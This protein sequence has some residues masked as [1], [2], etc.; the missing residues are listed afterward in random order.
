MTASG[1]VIDSNTILTVAHAVPAR[2]AIY[3][4]KQQHFAP[5][6][7]I[8]IDRRRDLALLRAQSLD[9]SPV[10]ISERPLEANEMV[11]ALG[12]PLAKEQRVSLG[13]FM[14]K[15]NDKIYSSTH[16]NSGVSGGSL[17]RCQDGQFELAGIVHGYVAQALDGVEVNLGDSTAVSMEAVQQFLN[18]ESL[19]LAHSAS[20]L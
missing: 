1:V 9:A 16:V 3:L 12:Y 4:N 19:V 14:K 2:E 8:K 6:K 10:T 17:L 7:V 5:L 15:E 18:S 20:S 11:W 13:A